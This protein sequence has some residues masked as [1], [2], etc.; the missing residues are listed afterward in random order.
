MN[1]SS[2]VPKTF[3][4]LF[5]NLFMELSGEPCALRMLSGFLVPCPRMKSRASNRR[6]VSHV[7]SAQ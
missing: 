2:A 1:W 5:G 3:H 6:F 7:F 4:F